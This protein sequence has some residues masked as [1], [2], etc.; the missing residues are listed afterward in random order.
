M[1]AETLISKKEVLEMTGI[2]YG[3]FYRWK[4]KGLIPESWFIRKST[5]TG[6]ETFLPREKVLE[7]IKKIQ[8]LKDD[9]SLEELAKLLSPEVSGRDF[10]TEEVGTLNWISE[11]VRNF[12]EDYRNT[13]GDYLFH[14]ILFL[15]V[16][17]KLRHQLD[18][19]TLALVISTLTLHEDTLQK[20]NEFHWHLLIGRKSV[21]TNLAEV[22]NASTV[23][24]CFIHD[25]SCLL[26][27]ETEQVVDIDL[28]PILEDI[29][30]KVSGVRKARTTG[31][32]T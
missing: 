31:K 3:Q 11:E 22:E 21:S 16:L 8:D 2:S 17:E 25:Q 1:D 9:H 27:A 30:L 7:R 20:T 15:T 29:K 32:E 6:Q 14:D 28:H 23:S 18:D 13:S 26:D 10:S 4:R 5:F 24:V 12:Y 19:D